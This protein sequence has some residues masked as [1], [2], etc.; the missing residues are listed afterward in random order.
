MLLVRGWNQYQIKL[1]WTDGPRHFYW[2]G[3]EMNDN[4]FYNQSSLKIDGEKRKR[5]MKR[6]TRKE[7]AGWG[8]Q[9][10]NQSARR[11]IYSNFTP[12]CLPTSVAHNTDTGNQSISRGRIYNLVYKAYSAFLH[13]DQIGVFRS[14]S[15]HLVESWDVIG[16]LSALE[17]VWC[18]VGLPI[19]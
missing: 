3:F 13:T 7:L 18:L 8:V 15:Q 5:R 19:R 14:A 16:G 12:E 17:E 6:K 11:P 9:S 2:L 1:I 4:R 10:I